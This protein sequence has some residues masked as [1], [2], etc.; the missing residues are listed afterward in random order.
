[1]DVIVCQKISC[2][3]EYQYNMETHYSVGLESRLWGIFVCFITYINGLMSTLIS[4]TLQIVAVPSSDIQKIVW[5][6]CSLL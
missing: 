5:N 3:L 4:E 1:M 2:M 6:F